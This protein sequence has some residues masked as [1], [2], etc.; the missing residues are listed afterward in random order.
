MLECTL[1]R[2]RVLEKLVIDTAGLIQIT[3]ASEPLSEEG[4]L[5]ERRLLNWLKRLEVNSFRIHL[6]GH[7][8]P[9]EYRE[10]IEAIKPKKVIPIHISSPETMVKLFERYRHS[11]P[12]T[13]ATY[14]EPL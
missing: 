14:S 3:L 4:W 6:S 12:R 7:Y 5:V 1:C 9:H 10:I 2:K 13:S 8:Y 11:T